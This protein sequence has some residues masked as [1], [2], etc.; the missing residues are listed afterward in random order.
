MKLLPNCNL[1]DCQACKRFSK[2]GNKDLRRTLG[3]DALVMRDSI[4]LVLYVKNKEDMHKAFLKVRDVLVA[5]YE[6]GK[7][8]R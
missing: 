8:S 1:E 3:D 4:N 2:S 5:Y 7:G 6:A